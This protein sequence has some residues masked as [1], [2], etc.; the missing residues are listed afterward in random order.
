MNRLT[1]SE[2]SRLETFEER[3]EYLKLSGVVASE[4]FGIDRYLNQK[5]YNSAE[6]K[7]VRNLVLARDNGCDLGVAGYDIFLKPIIHHINPIS[8]EDILNRND[9]L[10]DLDNL[11]TISE[12]THRALHYGGYVPYSNFKERTAGDTKLW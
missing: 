12:E 2:L 3:F 1:Y 10:F 6:W 4:T 11:I 7:R 5:F 8:K 9:C